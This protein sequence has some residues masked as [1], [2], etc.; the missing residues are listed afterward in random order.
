ME[1]QEEGT[2]ITRLKAFIEHCGL[3]NSQ[4]ADRAGIPR[5]TLSQ[6]IHGRNKSVNDLL[7]RKLHENFPALDISWLL[8]GVGSM[9]NESN[10][11]FSEP[12]NSPKMPINEFQTTETHENNDLFSTVNSNLQEEANEIF[13][14]ENNNFDSFSAFS[15]KFNGGERADMEI[16]KITSPS[17]GSKKI[18]SIIIFY[19]DSSF[20]VFSPD[21]PES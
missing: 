10:I 14:D 15:D 11:Q 17:S 2:V 3:S 7:L 21:N 18:K 6:L 20:E 8:F 5:P 9:L 19:T 13:E 12:Q 1:K 16:Q 4:F